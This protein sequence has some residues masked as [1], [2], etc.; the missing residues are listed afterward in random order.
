[1]VPS[2]SIT[3][4]FLGMSSHF[5]RQL[6]GKYRWVAHY[7]PRTPATL[8]TA[9]RYA[10]IEQPRA[11]RS[12]ATK[13]QGKSLRHLPAGNPIGPSGSATPGSGDL[14]HVIRAP[15]IQR[16]QRDIQGLTERSQ[17]VLDLGRHL[18]VD[19]PVHDP[20]ALQLPGLAM[21]AAGFVNLIQAAE[22][23]G[24]SADLLRPVR[25]LLDDAVAA[26]DQDL[27]ALVPRLTADVTRVG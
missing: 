22:D 1:M 7:A 4:S 27:A 6:D 9:R 8:P 17:R 19:L 20:P 3:P 15:G 16:G 5:C 24:V 11:A 14:V 23:Q 21:Q 18:V 25:R 26:G 13:S 12:E 10:L 2:S